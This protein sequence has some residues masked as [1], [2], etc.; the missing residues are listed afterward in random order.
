MLLLL[1]SSGVFVILCGFHIIPVLSTPCPPL[2]LFLFHFVPCI[3]TSVAKQPPPPRLVLQLLNSTQGTV[4]PVSK[5][6]DE[7]S[8]LA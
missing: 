3:T 1:C 8:L 6:N 4:Y 7:D 2:L 5:L